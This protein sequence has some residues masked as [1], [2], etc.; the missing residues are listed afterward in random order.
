MILIKFFYFCLWEIKVWVRRSKL[1]WNIRPTIST[2]KSFAP[3]AF[4]LC[5]WWIQIAISNL[6]FLIVKNIEFLVSAE[7][8]ALGWDSSN[9]LLDF[10]LFFYLKNFYFNRLLLFFSKSERLHFINYFL[11]TIFS[12]LVFLVLATIRVLQQLSRI[13]VCI[14]VWVFSFYL[15][16]FSFQL[17]ILHN[18]QTL[19]Y[20]L[21]K[22]L[23]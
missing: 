4:K 18:F 11:L 7:E 15:I 22:I 17:N 21:V 12:E 6:C 23:L 14:V 5:I 9:F 3:L 16:L 20:F 10:I 13:L 1:G 19:L 8:W 2:I